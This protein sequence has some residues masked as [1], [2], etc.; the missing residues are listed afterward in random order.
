MRLKLFLQRFTSEL[1]SRTFVENLQARIQREILVVKIFA[2]QFEA[3][4]MERADMGVVKKRELLGVT[5]VTGVF[6]QLI[7]Q[8][9]AKIL[10]QFGGGGLGEGNDEQFVQ[11]R[12]VAVEA[13]ETTGDEGGGFAGSGTSHD[14]HVAAGFDRLLLRQRWA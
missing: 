9:G 2:D 1:A 12:A 5:E 4:A 10:A 3:E 8:R 13:V 14:E 6:P 7:F 11:R